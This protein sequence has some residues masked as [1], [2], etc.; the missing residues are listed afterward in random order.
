ME[1]AK[2]LPR[3]PQK[4]KSNP[5]APRAQPKTKKRRPAGRPRM[6]PR[7]QF[8]RNC[9][10]THP[11]SIQS[12]KPR[13]RTEAF[14]SQYVLKHRCDTC[15]TTS[16]GEPL[17]RVPLGPTAHRAVGPSLPDL[18]GSLGNFALCGGRGRSFAPS[19]PTSL[20]K[21]GWTENLI[22][23]GGQALRILRAVPIIAAQV[24]VKRGIAWYNN[25]G[26][27]IIRS[28]GVPGDP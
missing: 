12:G 6:S 23:V 9:G 3:F 5:V 28:G 8:Q 11:Y 20:L 16:C 7:P 2:P 21:K 14:L 22:C 18:L 27:L 24:V 4:A 26:G 17:D 19:I 1:G 25:F 13:Q 10:M 15:R